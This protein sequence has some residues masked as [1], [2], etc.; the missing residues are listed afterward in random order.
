MGKTAASAESKKGKQKFIQISD[1]LIIIMFCLGLLSFIVITVMQTKGIPNPDDFLTEINK[2]ITGL[3][4]DAI[5]APKLEHNSEMIVSRV[6]ANSYFTRDGFDLSNEIIPAKA[7][8]IDPNIIIK[9]PSPGEETSPVA[10]IKVIPTGTSKGNINIEWTPAINEAC[11]YY[12]IRWWRMESFVEGEDFTDIEVRNNKPLNSD[13]S[14][15]EHELSF[16]IKTYRISDVTPNVKYL[17]DIQ[18]L[19]I[20]HEPCTYQEALENAY[21]AD[22]FSPGQE[23][24]MPRPMNFKIEKATL[25]GVELRWDTIDKVLRQDRAISYPN[26]DTIKVVIFRWK[27]SNTDEM[28]LLNPATEDNPFGTMFDRYQDDSIEPDIPY[29]YGIQYYHI[30]S[31]PDWDNKEINYLYDELLELRI[32]DVN[33]RNGNA[34]FED[35]KP[36]WITRKVYASKL[37]KLEKAIELKDRPVV[38]VKSINGYVNPDNTDSKAKIH[39]T[40]YKSLPIPED[41]TQSK[42]VRVKVEHVV[43][44]DEIIKGQ[45]NK[46]LEIDGITFDKT[47]KYWKLLRDKNITIEYETSLKIVGIHSIEYK[48]EKGSTDTVMYLEVKN[49]HPDFDD[50]WSFKLYRKKDINDAKLIREAEEN[51]ESKLNE[52]GLRKKALI[53]NKPEDRQCGPNK[54]ERKELLKK[55]RDFAKKHGQSKRWYN[56]YPFKFTRSFEDLLWEFSIENEIR[57]Y[58]RYYIKEF[59]ILEEFDQLRKLVKE[60][61]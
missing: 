4:G 42:F 47:S 36:V 10:N 2:M 1:I 11:K 56:D 23:K 9:I 57:F 54:D 17:I 19:D 45:T 41:P 52:N 53:P 30:E 37:I 3:K 35:N 51:G 14:E 59:P 50:N 39:L 25:A 26:T 49:I 48:Y 31:Y 28:E 15:G 46:P 20:D 13:N 7:V 18:S 43:H 16:K 5:S 24:A 32:Q 8:L 61:R 58:P 40:V 55:I 21:L 34:I 6:E 12:K 22:V 33:P 60:F 38:E 29:N 44:Y 27:N